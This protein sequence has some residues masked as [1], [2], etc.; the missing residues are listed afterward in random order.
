M[1]LECHTHSDPASHPA[2]HFVEGR[3]VPMEAYWDAFDDNYSPL[4]GMKHSTVEHDLADSQRSRIVT[5]LLN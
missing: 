1:I 2:R 5:M 4:R 3:Q